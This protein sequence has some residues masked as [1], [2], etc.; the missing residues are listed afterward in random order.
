M[1]QKSL[2]M[3]MGSVGKKKIGGSIFDLGQKNEKFIQPKRGGDTIEILELKKNLLIHRRKHSQKND[4]CK[5]RKTS[6]SKPNIDKYFNE[7]DIKTRENKENKLSNTHSE[8][9]LVDKTLF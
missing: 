9:P 1:M 5:S 2:E 4:G 7:I 3:I 8:V 6:K